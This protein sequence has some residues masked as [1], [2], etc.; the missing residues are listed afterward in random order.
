MKVQIYDQVNREQDITSSVLELASL[1]EHGAKRES[2]RPD[3]PNRVALRKVGAPILNRL[4]R[5]RRPASSLPGYSQAGHWLASTPVKPR[6][7][8]FYP[9]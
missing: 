8:P 1:E 9:C 2:P 6:R 7:G 3:F 4:L 5:S